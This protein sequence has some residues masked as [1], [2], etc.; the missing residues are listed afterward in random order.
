MTQAGVYTIQSPDDPNYQTAQTASRVGVDAQAVGTVDTG[1]PGRNPSGTINEFRLHLL[2]PWPMQAG[3]HYTINYRDVRRDNGIYP[4]QATTTI[5]YD[6]TIVNGSVQVNQI[7][8]MPQAPKIAF[9]G[10]WLGTAGPMPV[11]QYTFQLVDAYTQTVVYQGS[12]TPRAMNDMWSGNDVFV[13]D[14]SS[15]MRTGRYYLNVPGVGRSYAFTIAPDVLD[16]VYRTTMRVLYHKRNSALVPPYADPGRERRGGVP[17]Q[18]DGV[19]VPD[20]YASPLY[21]GEQI[22]QYKKIEPGWFDAGDLGE[23]ITNQS[24]VWGA[25]SAAMDLAAPGSFKDGEL[26]IPESGNGIPDILDELAWGSRWALSMQD[27]RDGGVYRTICS[28]SWDYVPPWQVAQP[29]YIFEKTTPATAQFAAMMAIYSRLIAPYDA[30]AAS[31]ARTAAIRAWDFV[32]THVTWPAEGSRYYNPPSGGCGEYP[33]YSSKPPKLWAAAE[34]YRLTGDAVYQQAFESI[35]NTTPVDVSAWT[36]EDVTNAAWAMLMSQHANRDPYLTQ[37]ARNLIMM[38]ANI[39]RSRM[40]SHPFYSSNHPFMGWVGW[41]SFSGSVMAVHKLLMAYYITHD[42]NFQRL[43]WMSPNIELGSNPQN[44]SYITG[45]GYNGPVHPLDPSVYDPYASYIRGEPVPGVTFHLPGFRQPYIAANN[46]YYPPDLVAG[47]T[48]AMDNTWRQ[49]YPI[50][51]RYTDSSALIPMAEPTVR[52]EALTGTAFALLR[53]ANLP[54][55]VSA[56]AYHWQ[57]GQEYRAISI[58]DIPLADVPLL[59]P[60]R[61]T[62]FGA[63]VALA[64]QTTLAALTPEQVGAI[65]APGMARWVGRLTTTQRQGLTMAQVRAFTNGTLFLDLLPEQVPW[66]TTANLRTLYPHALPLN[67]AAWMQQL[68]LPQLQEIQTWPIWNWQTNLTTTQRRLLAGTLVDTQA[69][70][71]NLPSPRLTIVTS[72][73]AS[74]PVADTR[75]QNW[76][77]A[78][79]ATDNIA[80]AG[81]LHHDAPYH[82]A[83]GQTVTVTFTAIDMAGHTTTATGTIQVILDQQPPVITPPSPITVKAVDAYGTPASDAMIARFLASVTASDNVDTGL[84]ISNDAPS[85]FPLGVTRVTFNTSDRAGNVATPVSSTVTVQNQSAPTV[86][87]PANI[88]VAAVNAAGTPATD[89][90][91]RA[92]LRGATAVDLLGNPLPVSNNAPAQLPLGTTTVTFSATAANH[93]TGTAMATITVRDLTAPT[94]TAPA[95]ISIVAV[96]AYGRPASDP[97]IT[98]FLNAATAVDNVD[99]AIAPHHNAP[100]QFPIGVTLVTFSAMDS[101]GNTGTATASITVQNPA[102]P[103]ITPTANAATPATGGGCQ[104]SNNETAPIDPVL[105]LLL[106][107][108]LIAIWRKH[109]VIKTVKKW[110]EQT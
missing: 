104:L 96:D 3:K 1:I 49:I 17:A 35:L 74:I 31:T 86:T 10:N 63:N 16:S 77:N 91:I 40:N 4:T 97:Y 34:L 20:M 42:T 53:N 54:T 69:P 15:V 23:Y 18:M 43:A 11:D 75:I 50:L 44:R 41:H 52:E 102:T 61:I 65:A 57:P 7:G 27:Q 56:T 13:A 14:F 92:F 55:R 19:F 45:I 76:L 98:A 110:K 81:R 67:N 107:C 33:L 87:P 8:Y 26:N 79:T 80:L 48:P 39:T 21:N 78:A 37:Q 73:N 85:V 108:S 29:R 103:T 70:V 62:A 6:P 68:T 25:V 109:V 24:Q 36:L 28:A 46:A 83:P 94:V 101:Y 95:A 106:V 90:Y 59:S 51:R 105:P 22:G 64:P 100:A 32:Q 9:V 47:L 2:L 71:I 93:Y 38:G 66:M 72:T 84:S 12:I 60:A 30:Y 5:V 82:F 89:P 99:G 58:A 88:T